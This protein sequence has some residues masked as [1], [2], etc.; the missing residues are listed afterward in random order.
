MLKTQQNTALF[1][2]YHLYKM[3]Y[4]LIIDSKKDLKI[5]L[6]SNNI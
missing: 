2:L 4:T 3:T 6:Y 5:K 1:I